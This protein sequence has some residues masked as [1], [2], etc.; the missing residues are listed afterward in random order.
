M[1]RSYLLTFSGI[2]GAGK[3][4]QIT[5]LTKYFQDNGKRPGYIWSRGGYTSF[6]EN[7]KSLLRR[8]L[9]RSLPPS[10]HSVKRS[11][12]FGKKGIRRLWLYAALL[13]LIRVY[14]INIRIWQMLGR[15]VICDRYLDD[16]LIDFKMN[17]PQEDVEQ[18]IL[19][20]L[21][22]WIAPRPDGSF[23]LMIPLEESIRRSQIKKDPF[24]EPEEL[25]HKRYALYKE[26]AKGGKFLVIDGTKAEVEVTEKIRKIVNSM[27]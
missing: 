3:S 23:L 12:Y 14:G 7:V 2:D 6:L 24:P 15:P 16:T 1:K 21:L 19:W 20:R 27:Q 13:D 17:F 9:K 10:G 8:I 25:R 11:Q 4:T 26:L 5:H 18:W 22:K